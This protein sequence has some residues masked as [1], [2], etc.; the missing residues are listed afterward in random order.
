[1]WRG[2]CQGRPVNM[3]C[4]RMVFPRVLS[5]FQRMQTT[6]RVHDFLPWNL[7]LNGLPAQAGNEHGGDKPA[8]KALHRAAET[9]PPQTKL[10]PTRPRRTRRGS[11]RSPPMRVRSSPLI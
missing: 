7:N 5:V 2:D 4:M 6:G 10:R 3:Y 1:M 9:R 8:A 11:L